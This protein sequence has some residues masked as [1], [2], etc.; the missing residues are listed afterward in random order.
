MGFDQFIPLW[1]DCNV[2]F[3]NCDDNQCM[4]LMH[5]YISE[6]LGNQDIATLAVPQA[7][8]LATNYPNYHNAEL[9]N[10]T[11]NTPTNIPPKGAIIVWFAN[12]VVGIPEGHVAMVVNADVNQFTSFDSNFPTGQN[13]HL[14]GH[15]YTDVAGWLTLK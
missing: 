12:A 14:Q 8:L 15:D 7:S 11:P 9:F 2:S 4:T 13:P 6:V 10:W 1:T 3:P 5:R